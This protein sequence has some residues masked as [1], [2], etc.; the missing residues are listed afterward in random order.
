MQKVEEAGKIIGFPHGIGTTSRFTSAAVKW[1]ARRGTLEINF[2]KNIEN[3][4]GEPICGYTIS[5]ISDR[6]VV[7]T[8]TI[9]PALSE[10]LADT[11]L[12]YRDS[13]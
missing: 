11:I 10:A 1:L 5:C 13:E 12:T 6:G 3:G 7:G 2:H 8:P 9:V 4:L